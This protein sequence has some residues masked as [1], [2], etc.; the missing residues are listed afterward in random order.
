MLLYARVAWFNFATYLAYPLELLATFLKPFINLGFTLLFWSIIAASSHGAINFRQIIS[1]LLIAS[2]VST[3]LLLNNLRL[4]SSLAKAIKS[5]D[6]SYALIRPV[7]VPFFYLAVRVGS[8]GMSYAVSAVLLIAGLIMQ[9]PASALSFVLFLL[10]LPPAMA[11]SYCLNMFVGIIAFYFTE[12]DSIK[13]VIGHF[14]NVFS[15][16]IVPLT[17]FPG[18][19]KTIVLL[20]PFAT[21]VFG[22][23]HALS[24]AAINTQTWLSLASGYAWAIVLLMITNKLWRKS[25]RQYEAVGM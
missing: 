18:T 11:I 25:L 3:A 5:G 7:I 14:I 19:L 15:G 2:A 23:A 12:A 16:T 8:L 10:F 6:I 17:F 20:L 4:G 22:P 13:N 1:Y 24:N 21:A 9:P